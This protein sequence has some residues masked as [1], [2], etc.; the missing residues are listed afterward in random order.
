MTLST[1]KTFKAAYQKYV[2]AWYAKPLLS[3]FLSPQLNT[4]FANP[5][6]SAW[7]IFCG[8]ESNTNAFQRWMF[9][10]LNIFYAPKFLA[11]YR[12][13]DELI[14]S[15]QSATLF[16]KLADVQQDQLGAEARYV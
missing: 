2:S 1:I 6:S 10:F 15:K 9:S 7:D 11:I 3:L 12:Q 14:P 8:I 5:D 4:L 13:Y 16:N